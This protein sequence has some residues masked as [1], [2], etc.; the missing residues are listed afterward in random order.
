MKVVFCILTGMICLSAEA[1]TINVNVVLQ[2]RADS[3]LTYCR[4][5]QLDTTICILINMGMH[6]GKNRLFVWNFKQQ[7]VIRAGLV[8]HGIGKGS[9]PSLP[10]FSNVPESYCTSLGKYR[11]GE[12]GYSNY[13]IHV[14]Y[15]L[16]GMEKTNNNAY[17][18]LIVLHSHTP[19]PSRE[20]YPHHLPTG[21]SLGCPVV[22]EE[23][24]HDLDVMLR[25]ATRAVLLWIYYEPNEIVMQK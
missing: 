23:V 6:S 10:V 18:R 24:M 12:R 11:I 8:C 22:S 17:R 16:H 9:T 21:Y 1:M 7:K 15:R 2:P 4:G 5:H 20:I 13:G 14:L 19:M 3:A 25:K